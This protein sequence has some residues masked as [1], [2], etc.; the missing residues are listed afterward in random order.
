MPSYDEDLTHLDEWVRRLKV[1]YEIFF[2][3]HRKRPP[4]DLRLRVEKMVKR[5]AESGDMTFSQ[6]F[7]YNTLIARYY[8]YRDLWRRTLQERE[9][10]GALQ[11]EPENSEPATS[12]SNQANAG[13]HE[14]QISIR[15]PKNETEKVHYLYDEL[16]RMKGKHASGTPGISFEQFAD[17]ISNQTHTI[18]AKHACPSVRFRIAL[19]QKTLRFTA[20]ADQNTSS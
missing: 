9:S 4:E 7:R 18:K 16:V 8:V 11:T 6:R 14:I 10:A 3:G 15:D 20:K 12:K 13:G 2:N 17:Y 1:E 5:L 19:E